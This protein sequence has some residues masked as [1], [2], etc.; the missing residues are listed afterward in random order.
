MNLTVM[1]N[2]PIITYTGST[3]II[4]IYYYELKGAKVGTKWTLQDQAVSSYPNRYW[5]VS[6][7]V[8]YVD[9]DG[10]LLLYKNGLGNNKD[11]IWV[12]F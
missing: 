7:E 8:L 12:D 11:L 2:K 6:Y 4:E 9:T 5:K 10:I 1:P 3:D